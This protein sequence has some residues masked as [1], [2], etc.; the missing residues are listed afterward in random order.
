MAMVESEDW[1][2]DEPTTLAITSGASCPD[3]L[4][5]DV[6]EKIASFFGYGA[7]EIEAGLSKLG[8]CNEAA[9]AAS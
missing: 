3:T 6:V 1:L 5:N 4:M 9:V 7:A 2:P 8:L